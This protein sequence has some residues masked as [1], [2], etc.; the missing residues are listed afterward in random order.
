MVIWWDLVGAVVLQA[1]CTC[2]VPWLVR[3]LGEA[4]ERELSILCT[5]WIP[6]QMFSEEFHQSFHY[7]SIG[8]DVCRVLPLGDS[9]YIIFSSIF[10]CGCEP[11]IRVLW[12]QKTWVQV[13][14]PSLPNLEH[15]IHL[16]VMTS[17][18][19]I[20]GGLLLWNKKNLCHY[21]RICEFF[22]LETWR[23]HLKNLRVPYKSLKTTQALD[24]SLNFPQPT[25]LHLWKN[26]GNNLSYPT[27]VSIESKY[28]MKIGF[29][30]L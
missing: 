10:V 21:P 30:K 28:G 5:A 1:L 20:F 6:L 14:H 16:L 18:W 12:H 11:K 8:I 15:L 29:W 19:L 4:L 9:L 26:Y 24:K 27:T 3:I 25:F 17:T 22:H 2:L 13:L 23:K 7:S